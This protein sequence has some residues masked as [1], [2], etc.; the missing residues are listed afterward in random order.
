MDRKGLT[1][2]SSLVQSLSRDVGWEEKGM[3]EQRQ[4]VRGEA[5]CE[6]CIPLIHWTISMII[7]NKNIVY[8]SR[9][10]LTVNLR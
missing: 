1:T 8:L 3:R 7:G 2:A 10:L 6:T 4:A 9:V 5:S